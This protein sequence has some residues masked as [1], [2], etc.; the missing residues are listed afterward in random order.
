MDT[1]HGLG[2][3]VIVDIVLHHGAPQLNA[4]WDYDGWEE[5]ANGGWVQ[6]AWGRGTGGTKRGKP[7]GGWVP[8]ERRPGVHMPSRDATAA[9][10]QWS[11]FAPLLQAA[12][13]TR[14]RR[15]PCGAGSWPS[16][17]QRCVYVVEPSH[18]TC[19]LPSGPLRATPPYR[20][21]LRWWT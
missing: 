21:R 4:L 19:L 15:T 17:N 11:S 12:S 16:G 20:P 3:G 2:L 10:V 14:A 9:V 13:T 1:A 5:G 18:H 8:S 7:A 6:V